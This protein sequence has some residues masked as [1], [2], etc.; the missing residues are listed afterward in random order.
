MII[1]KKSVPKEVFEKLEA[2]CKCVSREKNSKMLG[3]VKLHVEKGQ[4]FLIATDGHCM[5]VYDVTDVKLFEFLSATR[6]RVYKVEKVSRTKIMLEDCTATCDGV[7]PNWKRVT[8]D[9]ADYSRIGFLSDSMNESKYSY[10]TYTLCTHKAMP[11]SYELFDKVGNVH[12]HAAV[13]AHKS[14]MSKPVVIEYGNNF[15][16]FATPL[17]LNIGAQA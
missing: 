3:Y 4:K 16:W 13:F 9:M 10:L 12:G 8:P 17:R 15:K 2:C 7:F 11:V 1:E 6:C 14:D 5:S